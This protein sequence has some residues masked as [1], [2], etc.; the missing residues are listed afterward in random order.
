MSRAR[1]S[2]GQKRLSGSAAGREGAPAAN[3]KHKVWAM[4]VARAEEGV[5]RFS[6]DDGQF[7][8]N[9]NSCYF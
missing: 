1:H 3:D 6:D 2:L 5:V 7:L 9:T 4:A 8:R